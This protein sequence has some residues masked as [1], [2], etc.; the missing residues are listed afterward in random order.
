MI[1][2]TLRDT[3]GRIARAESRELFR[4]NTLGGPRGSAVVMQW[5]DMRPGHFDA[6]LL[7]RVRRTAAGQGELIPLADVAPVALP[8]RTPPP[9]EISG[10][11]VLFGE[12]P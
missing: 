7:P 11:D 12:M 2:I 9:A 10:Q 1:E 6:S 8:A 5:A 3:P 4:F